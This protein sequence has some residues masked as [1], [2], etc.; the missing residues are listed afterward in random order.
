MKNIEIGMEAPEVIAAIV[1]GNSAILSVFFAV[2]SPARHL[3]PAYI[4][5]KLLRHNPPRKLIELKR[6]EIVPEN[7]RGL[8]SHF[9]SELELLAFVSRVKLQGKEEF[10][11]LPLIDFRSEISAQNLR[12][13]RG[14]LEQ[15]GQEEGVILS[16]GAS[17]HYYGL[18]PLSEPDWVIFLG[19]CLLS[20]LVDHFYIG[21]QLI[22]KCSIVRI[23]QSSQY[24]EVPTVASTFRKMERSL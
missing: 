11:H 20:E 17:Y 14:F 23:S 19:Q 22:D 4:T 10:F 16:S 21:H 12:R 2:Y 18:E 6:G 13:I 3:K 8:T 24:P 15:V 7:I 9:V 5:N 1:N